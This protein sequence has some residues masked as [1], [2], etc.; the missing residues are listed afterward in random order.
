MRPGQKIVLAA[1]S[2][3]FSLAFCPIPAKATFDADLDFHASARNEIVEL[4][5]T[6]VVPPRLPNVGTVFLWPGLQPDPDGR[7]FLPINNGVLQS[8]LT[9]GNSCAPPWEDQ[10]ITHSSWWI[11]AQYVND[12]GCVP[13]FTG[14]QGGKIMPVEPGDRLRIRFQLSG[15]EWSQSILD[16]R[17]GQEVTFAFDLKG[18]AQT[19]AIFAIET[20][21]EAIAP[22]VVVFED[23]ALRFRH[24][25]R[26]ACKVDDAEQRV[27]GL[28]ALADGLACAIQRIRLSKAETVS[29]AETDACFGEEAH[30]DLSTQATSVR[31]DNNSNSKVRIDWIDH[32]GNQKRYETLRPG[33]S[34]SI[35]SYVTHLW[36]A[37]DSNGDCKGSFKVH[38]GYN[39]FDVR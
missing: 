15:T 10:P 19:Y 5:A 29:N 35:T 26:A 4:Q 20:N 2:L 37:V 30:S 24:P 28:V 39:V 32:S 7:D 9:W 8:V 36:E 11:S 22:S 34:R 21:E 33:Q 38:S 23:V 16:D 31:I 3:A 25:D 6:L 27:I 1:A 18:Q 17:T 12:Y 14:C 13:G